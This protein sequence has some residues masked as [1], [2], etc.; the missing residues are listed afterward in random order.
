MD[1]WTDDF[2]RRP[3]LAITAHFINDSWELKSALLG[4]FPWDPAMRQTAENLQEVLVE[5]K[6]IYFRLQS[7]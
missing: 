5:V 2:K 6:L 3:Y 4:I 1:F 7:L